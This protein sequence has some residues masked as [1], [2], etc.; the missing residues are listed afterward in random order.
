VL[1]SQTKAYSVVTCMRFS[2]SGMFNNL[3]VT[4]LL[5]NLLVKEFMRAN[6]SIYFSNVCRLCDRITANEKITRTLRK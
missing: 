2:G 6:V 3:F 4:H 1:L 5:L